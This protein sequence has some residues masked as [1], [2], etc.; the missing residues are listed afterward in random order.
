MAT[1][2]QSRPKVQPMS[3]NSHGKK[4]NRFFGS[5]LIGSGV[6]LVIAL[7]AVGIFTAQELGTSHA[8]PVEKKT[9]HGGAGAITTINGL[10]TITQIGSATNILDN[11]GNPVTANSDP[12]K[13]VIVPDGLASPVLKPGNLLVSNIGN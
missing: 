11:N 8:A 2:L 9:M 12:Y 1:P 7:L 13:I 6:T 10:N 5:M 3:S 4:R